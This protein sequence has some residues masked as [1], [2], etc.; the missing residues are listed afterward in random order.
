MWLPEELMCV[1]SLQWF[2]GSA[3]PGSLGLVMGHLLKPLQAKEMTPTSEFFSS[4]K[5]YFISFV[6]F[7]PLLFCPLFLGFIISQVLDLWG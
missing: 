4:G 3:S 5:L 6:I 1:Q 7:S 2:Q